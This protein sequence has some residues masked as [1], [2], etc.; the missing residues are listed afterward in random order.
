MES[1]NIIG[2]VTFAA[3][4]SI[5]LFTLYY[6]YNVF[7]G[8][9][10][11]PQIFEVKAAETGVPT[12][13]PSGFPTSAQEVQEMISQQLKDQLNEMISQE[14]LF[15]TFNLATWAIGASVLIFGGSKIAELGVKLIRK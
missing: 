6:S 8:Q 10:E 11:V 14:S 2:W 7:T 1:S 12:A 5:I 13:T 15:K 3:G 4:I 9:L